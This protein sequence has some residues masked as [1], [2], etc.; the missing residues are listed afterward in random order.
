MTRILKDDGEELR[1]KFNIAGWTHQKVS[2]TIRSFH[3]HP[4]LYYT[5][6]FHQSGGYN[7]TRLGLSVCPARL[8][9][10]WP[11]ALPRCQL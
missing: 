3:F 2:Q 8:N 5:V 6:Y 10:E 9:L 4:P 7:K 1:I 11:V